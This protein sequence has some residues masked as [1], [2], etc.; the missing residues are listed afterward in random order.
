MY[1]KLGKENRVKVKRKGTPFF[2]L[3]KSSPVYELTMI[4]HPPY[5]DYF[6]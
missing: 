4:N 5:K 6:K 1:Q 3:L 2:F